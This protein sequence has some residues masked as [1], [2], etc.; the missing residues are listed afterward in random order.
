MTTNETIFGKAG[1]LFLQ[2]SEPLVRFLTSTPVEYTI[3]GDA[4]FRALLQEDNKQAM[5]VYW[6]ELIGR[7]HLAAATSMIRSYRWCEGMMSSYESGLFLPYCACFRG[8]LESVADTYDALNNVA[9][10]I[11]ENSSSINEALRKTAGIP[12]L[13]GDLENQ[14][15]HFAFAHK[16]QKGNAVPQTHIAKTVAD[17]MRPLVK[18]GFTELQDLY[19]ELCQYTHPAAHSIHYLLAEPTPET[20]V[21]YGEHEALRIETHAKRHAAVFPDLLM[22]GFNPAFLVLKVLRHI[23]APS[24]QV[25]SVDNLEASNIPAW[26]RIE[27]FLVASRPISNGL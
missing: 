19:S 12:S 14:L 7:A 26:N 3:M 13:C 1:A 10:T 17:Y 23:E 5:K 22:F 20:F 16:P 27:T 25:S 9:V 4:Q 8:L 24:F 15:I 6:E 11:A 2:N 18:S 21:L